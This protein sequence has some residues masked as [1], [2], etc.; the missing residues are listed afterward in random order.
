MRASKAAVERHGRPERPRSS[1]GRFVRVGPARGE[2]IAIVDGLRAGERVVTAGQIKLQAYL[3][4]DD[5]RDGRASAA[6]RNAAAVT[7]RR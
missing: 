4:V 2:R 1:S 3:P 5:R 6:G 7:D